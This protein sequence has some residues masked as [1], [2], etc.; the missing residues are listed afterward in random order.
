MKKLT[1]ILLLVLCLAAVMVG[2]GKE[3]PENPS[4]Q[5]T[6]LGLMVVPPTDP[7]TQ[8]STEPEIPDHPEI[9]AE[10]DGPEVA[11]ATYY[12][13]DSIQ[14]S[15]IFLPEQ[16]YLLDSEGYWEGS[17]TQRGNT[18]TLVFSNRNEQGLLDEDG[19]L[20]LTDRVGDFVPKE[21]GYGWG[22]SLEYIQKEGDWDMKAL[23]GTWYNATE[24]ITL[25]AQNNGTVYQVLPQVMME[26]YCQKHEE[27]YLIRF[28]L[29]GRFFGP[30][31]AKLNSAGELVITGHDGV[32]TKQ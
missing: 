30:Y 4:T 10:P 6:T 17:Y 29:G 19:T 24:N 22:P 3:S 9:P 1:G 27:G 28:S 21:S 8:P 2:C 31:V 20:Y 26:G 23:I 18:V 25:V 14:M 15:L 5:A 12:D 32:Y 7:S 16:V 13:N 11:L